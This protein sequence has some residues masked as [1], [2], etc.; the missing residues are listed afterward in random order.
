MRI[1]IDSANLYVAG[2]I[3]DLVQHGV[4]VMVPDGCPTSPLHLA[5]E[6][7]SEDDALKAVEY[8]YS[9]GAQWNLRNRQGWTAEEYALKLGRS[10]VAQLIHKFGI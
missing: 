4:S 7:S 8:L 9:V 5:V 1:S 10:A 2:D 3:L 6:I